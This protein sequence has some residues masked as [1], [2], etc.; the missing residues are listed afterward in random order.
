MERKINCGEQ[1]GDFTITD[2]DGNSRELNE[3]KGKVVII[4]FWSAECPWAKRFDETVLPMI[5][6]WNGEVVLLQ[7]AS[8]ANETLDE[9]KSVATVRGLDLIL[10]DS[11]QA[12]ANMFG[13]VT[14]PHVY[15]I[16]REGVLRYQGA[17]D[18]VKFR[19]PEPT[20][21]YLELA[22]EALL[23]GKTPELDSVD[24]YGCTV[25]YQV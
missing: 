2:L 20:I 19:Q 11:D 15:I 5:D 13:A 23:D 25:V 6:A 7:I 16:D 14:T 3:F 24:P 4:N 9:I 8:N 1:V 12:V 22:V 18:D 21:N 17:F 10:L